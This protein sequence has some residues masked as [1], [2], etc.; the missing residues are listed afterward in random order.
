[1]SIVQEVAEWVHTRAQGAVSADVAAEFNVSTSRA[2][3]IIAA[4]HREPRFDTRVEK[5]Q[6]CNSL[7]AQASGR[8]LY[9]DKVTPS[10][11]ECKSV[12]GTYRNGKTVQFGSIHEAHR[13]MGFDREMISRCLRG[14]QKHHRGYTWAAITSNQ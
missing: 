3:G 6:I 1:M 5:C 9:V 10:Q 8:R 4:I 11:W 14:E 2:S 7:G 13:Q 12:I